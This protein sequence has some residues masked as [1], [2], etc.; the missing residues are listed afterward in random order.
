V[1]RPT[2]ALEDESPSRPPGQAGGQSPETKRYYGFPWEHYWLDRIDSHASPVDI[3]Y[4]LRMDAALDMVKPKSAA[5]CAIDV[6]C[7]I[8]IYALN[9]AA[10]M[11]RAS[12]LGVDISPAQIDTARGL[13]DRLGLGGRARFVVADVSSPDFAVS[14]GVRFD[15]VL[16]TEVVEHFEEPGPLLRNLR[17]LCKAGGSIILSVPIARRI[18]ESSYFYRQLVDGTWS[19]TQDER[20]LDPALGVYRYFHKTYMPGEFLRLC[21]SSGLRVV[22]RRYCRFSQKRAASSYDRAVARVARLFDSRVVAPL[23]SSVDHRDRLLNAI[24]SNRFSENL[25]VSA[26]C[27]GT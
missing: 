10:R 25:V 1:T 7:G 26:M 18:P 22:R 8:G 20:K 17:H 15:V 2:T 23:A 9:L 13:S 21:R 12:L 6:G 3:K 24:T 11:P 14:L 4:R 5:F 27:N 19:E 16:C